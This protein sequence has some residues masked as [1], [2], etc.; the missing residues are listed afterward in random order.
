MLRNQWLTAA[1]TVVAAYITQYGAI[2]AGCDHCNRDCGCRKVCR[3]VCEEKKVEITC[4]GVEC[5]DFCLPKHG[6]PGC[7]HCELVC[8]EDC[9]DPEQKV[10]TGPKK[11]VWHDWCAG[12]AKIYTKKKLMKKVVTKKVPTYKWVV[13][14]LCGE[15]ESKLKPIDVPA[16]AIVPPKPAAAFGPRRSSDLDL[17]GFVQ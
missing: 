2:A 14:D 17:T 10:H 4:W 11:F 5:E 13:E 3:L 15:C 16:D 12:G 7:K 8:D 1:L 6:K 9:G